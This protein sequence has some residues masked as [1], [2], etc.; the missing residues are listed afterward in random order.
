[1]SAAPPQSS[2]TQQ[3]LATGLKAGGLVGMEAASDAGCN[4]CLAV[5]QQ[6]SI[7]Q[8]NKLRKIKA[9]EAAPR[10]S[11]PSQH[12]LDLLTAVGRKLPTASNQYFWLTK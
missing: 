1:M 9:K 6:F 4:Q 3:T 2:L 5:F 12:I 7:E 10:F 8:S 11:D